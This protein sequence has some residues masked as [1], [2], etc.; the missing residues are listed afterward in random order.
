MSASHQVEPQ[1]RR[2]DPFDPLIA[3]FGEA[4]H[5]EKRSGTTTA[6]FRLDDDGVCVLCHR[7]APSRDLDLIR[8]VEELLTYAEADCR[9]PALL[10]VAVAGGLLPH[11]DRPDLHLIERYV[12]DGLRTVL[13]SRSEAIS[14][15]SN[16]AREHLTAVSGGG[17]ELVVRG[18]GK[19]D[20]VA[21]DIVMASSTTAET[22][23]SG[24]RIPRRF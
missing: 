19:L 24:L 20:L 15:N 7:R 5:Q 4:L 10:V 8:G 12:A 14:R 21:F 9:L 18:L 3:R 16:C 2:T 23:S 22:A 6:V 13:W 11:A 17:A 1:P